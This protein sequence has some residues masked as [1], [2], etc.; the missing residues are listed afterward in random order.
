VLIATDHDQV[1]YCM[2]AKHAKLVVDTRNACAR[3]GADLIRLS[4]HKLW[5]PLLFCEKFYSSNFAPADD[6]TSR[7][8]IFISEAPVAMTVHL[9]ATPD[10]PH[11]C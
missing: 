3:A 4:L 2:V 1:N 6:V 10:A 7:A 9:S 5:I 11:S 8:R